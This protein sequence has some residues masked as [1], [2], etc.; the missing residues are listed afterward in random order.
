MKKI[1]IGLSQCFIYVLS[2][3]ILAFAIGFV[4]SFILAIAEEY[5]FL[6]HGLLL[7]V[8]ETICYT[9]APLMVGYFT[10]SILNRIYRKTG[11]YAAS[12]IFIIAML[13]YVHLSAIFTTISEAGIFSWRTA[14]RIWSSAILCCAIFFGLE[15]Q[16]YTNENILS[17]IESCKRFLKSGEIDNN[18]QF[19]DDGKF[20]AVQYCKKC[21]AP[22][23]RKTKKCTGCGHQYFSFKR[24]LPVLSILCLLLIGGYFG[25]TFYAN[26]QKI[27]EDNESLKSQIESLE[28]LCS[29]SESENKQLTYEV[30]QLQDLR[31]D[32]MELSKSRSNNS[33][34][35]IDLKSRLRNSSTGNKYASC[36]SEI[37][38]VKKGKSRNIHINFKAVN[39]L[40]MACNDEYI[41]ADWVD[42]ST[43]VK[44]TGLKE[45]VTSMTFSTDAEGSNSFYIVILCYE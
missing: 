6:S 19:V 42:N 16:Q 13:L 3:E 10:V 31:D 18:T 24:L 1:A 36:G 34:L 45:G 21:G 7:N 14:N 23:E 44:V 2:Y 33:Q 30:Q 40:Y 22:I 35:F 11:I 26:Y 37:Y 39:T 8:V 28:K 38:S 27:M 32:A 4:Q 9:I 12:F 41:N 20:Y 17:F 43:D 5:P 29:Q 25:V 15:K